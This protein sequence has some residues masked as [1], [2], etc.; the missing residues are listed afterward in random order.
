MS[1]HGGTTP[2]AWV[3]RFA[4]LLPA[5]ARVLD[6]ACGRGRHARFL[7]ERGCHVIAADRDE[8]ALEVMSEVPGVVTCHL[9]LEDG[10]AWPWDK[11]AF[12]AVV[13]SNYLFRPAFAQLCDRVAPEGLLIYETFM[14][15]NERFGRP[16]N[17][18]FLLQPGEL[19]ARTADRFTPIAFEQGTI[20]EP[21][22][23]AVQRLCARKGTGPGHVPPASVL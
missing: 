9:D 14:V 11:D 15:G 2:S 1:T 19:L 13:V 18:D 5:G 3:V 23:A 8:A 12:D 20:G 21:P 22:L 17:P 10:S 6:L 7:A 4:S 16:T